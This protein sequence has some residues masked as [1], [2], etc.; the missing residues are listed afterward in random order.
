MNYISTWAR[1]TRRHISTQARKACT[2][3]TQ[4]LYMGWMV[5]DGLYWVRL[6]G[7]RLEMGERGCTWAGVGLK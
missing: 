7:C 4:G 2:H 1:E 6:F 5:G 3:K